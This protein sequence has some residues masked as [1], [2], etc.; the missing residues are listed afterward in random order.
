MR[1][2]VLVQRPSATSIGAGP[3]TRGTRT[4]GTLLRRHEVAADPGLPGI[5]RRCSGSAQLGFAGLDSALYPT[6]IVVQGFL[7][8]N[9]LCRCKHT[10]VPLPC[11]LTRSHLFL[12]HSVYCMPRPSRLVT[13]QQRVAW[14]APFRTLNEGIERKILQWRV[15]FGLE[16]WRLSETE[17]RRAD[18]GGDTAA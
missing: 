13:N 1:M 17:C 12:F 10:F 2:Q 14:T 16:E 4:L 11:D 5:A 8:C 7:H 6:L 18:V 3:L 9:L 15:D